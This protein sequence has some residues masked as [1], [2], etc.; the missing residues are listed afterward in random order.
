MLFLVL[1]A[2]RSALILYSPPDSTRR[3]AAS[4]FDRQALEE[5]AESRRPAV[6]RRYI[7]DPLNE[8]SAQDVVATSCGDKWIMVDQARQIQKSAC[9]TGD[10]RELDRG[11]AFTPK[12]ARA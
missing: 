10:L 12:W 8:C 2:A 7:I 1:L 5:K 4:E 3:L 6:E 9:A 11:G